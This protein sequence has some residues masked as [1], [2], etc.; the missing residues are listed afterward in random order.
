MKTCHLK[1]LGKHTSDD[2]D[3]VRSSQKRA[4]ADRKNGNHKGSVCSVRCSTHKKLFSVHNLTDLVKHLE[5]NET[6]RSDFDEG[7]QS[8]IDQQKERLNDLDLDRPQYQEE[9]NPDAD[10]EVEERN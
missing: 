3:P 10:A 1:D 8:Y 2:A 4:W 5:T 9:A 7:C 6:A